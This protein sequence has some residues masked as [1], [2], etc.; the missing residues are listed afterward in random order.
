MDRLLSRKDVAML[1]GVEE[2]TIYSWTYRKKI[3]FIKLGRLIKFRESE[4]KN[5]LDTKAVNPSVSSSR[6]PQKHLRASKSNR[7]IQINR[8]VAAA[9][10]EVLG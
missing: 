9:R 3:P 1:L 7:D 6:M 8:M 5:W 4:I 10:Q 2:S